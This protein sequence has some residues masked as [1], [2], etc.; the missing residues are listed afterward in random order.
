MA[1]GTFSIVAVSDRAI[2]IP[3]TELQYAGRPLTF[4]A[5]LLSTE[6][7]AALIHI[8]QAITPHF[9]IQCNAPDTD[10]V[11][12]AS[13][14]SDTHTFQ[15]RPEASFP[16]EL[17]IISA[18]IAS[19]LVIYGEPDFQYT[20]HA[21]LAL[22]GSATEKSKAHTTLAI[23]TEVVRMAAALGAATKAFA[24]MSGF[25]SFYGKGL[26]PSSL[27]SI[28]FSILSA[29]PATVFYRD[30]LIAAATDI[31][32][33]WHN[34][35]G[36]K[37][38][39][40]LRTSTLT[41]KRVARS[42]TLEAGA[43]VVLAAMYA[44]A[45]VGMVLQNFPHVFDHDGLREYIWVALGLVNLGVGIKNTKTVL[46]GLSRGAAT[47]FGHIKKN[48]VSEAQLDLLVQA[49]NHLEKT[50]VLREQLARNAFDSTFHI[51]DARQS[52][53]DAAGRC[54]NIT[55]ILRLIHR[56]IKSTE[57]E[58]IQLN[59][60]YSTF[61]KRVAQLK[62]EPASRARNCCEHWPSQATFAGLI[63]Q[64]VTDTPAAPPVV[65]VEAPLLDAVPAIKPLPKISIPIPGYSVGT[66]RFTTGFAHTMSAAAV[67]A[68]VYG[69]MGFV[70][71][72]LWQDMSIANYWAS[73]L[74]IGVLCSVAAHGIN[75]GDTRTLAYKI[76]D[77]IQKLPLCGR[78]SLNISL[79]T[80]TASS[81]AFDCKSLPAYLLSFY[82]ALSSL[83][84][85]DLT[86]VSFFG[87]WLSVFSYT[88]R[89]IIDFSTLY[90]LTTT[91]AEPCARLIKR[92]TCSK[93]EVTAEVV[94]AHPL[95]TAFEDEQ[96]VL[97]FKYISD[98]LGKIHA[99]PLSTD[100]RRALHLTPLNQKRQ[101]EAYVTQ[102]MAKI[103][104]CSSVGLT[105]ETRSDLLDV[106]Q[107]RFAELAS[108]Y[109]LLCEAHAP[110]THL[111]SGNTATVFRIGDEGLLPLTGSAPSV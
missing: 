52:F 55:G 40:A 76:I 91:K 59:Q 53:K 47:C 92:F 71:G 86:A 15:S 8:A 79:G 78:L 6:Q 103:T 14:S 82:A 31:E 25:L 2:D 45:N 90:L 37:D 58:L 28:V 97:Y 20:R 9:K 13:Y 73:D 38:S 87:T 85:A 98:L 89:G 69:A 60:T 61:E 23:V 84:Y 75:L 12:I 66:D 108:Y 93:T 16:G 83:F 1:Q 7:I 27:P 65:E 106:L 29:I 50:W 42:G 64:I 48:I 81:F 18:A 100:K 41:K 80:D 56:T 44:T 11:E 22:K 26:D 110:R 104:E 4:E 39:I 105:A 68:N 96:I 36:P 74:P 21:P 33:R 102:F 109:N 77:L 54:A 24:G 94:Y 17:T 49:L 111:P 72:V 34:A 101:L 51:D 63:E 19:E 35:H 107:L 43:N 70:Q 32:R 99:D 30:N 88:L 57:D 3:L 67:A 62:P 10:P 5:G 95:T 46:A